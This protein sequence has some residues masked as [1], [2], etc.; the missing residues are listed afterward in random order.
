MAG[1]YVGKIA[2]NDLVKTN[3]AIKARET[4]SVS[5]NVVSSGGG[6]LYIKKARR[7][8]TRR[9]TFEEEEERTKKMSAKERARRVAAK[10]H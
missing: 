10:W 3:A 8:V 9:E 4:R 5:R 6:V 1:L 7:M 2:E